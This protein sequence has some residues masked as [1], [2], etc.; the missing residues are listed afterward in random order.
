M[1]Y[2]ATALVLG[3]Y[4]ALIWRSQ[5]KEDGLPMNSSQINRHL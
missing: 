5:R 4:A 2:L 3:S 1:A